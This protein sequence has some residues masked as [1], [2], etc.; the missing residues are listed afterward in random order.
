M[1]WEEGPAIPRESRHEPRFSS[2]DGCAYCR[3]SGQQRDFYMSH[4]I[5]EGLDGPVTCPVLRN[6]T[7]PVCGNRGGDN[8]HTIRY[9][10][11]NHGQVVSAASVYRT[12]RMSNGRQRLPVANTRPE[13]KDVGA[14]GRGRGFRR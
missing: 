12:P 13:R 7:C 11:M 6:Y 3:S 8:A 5:R 14:A 2:F 4:S 1:K 9:C 10:P